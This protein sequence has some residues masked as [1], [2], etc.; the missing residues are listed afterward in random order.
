MNHVYLLDELLVTSRILAVL[1]RQTTELAFHLVAQLQRV[2]LAKEN[3]LL[4]LDVLHSVA[5]SRVLL[6]FDSA[7]GRRA[8]TKER[9][10]C[11]NVCQFID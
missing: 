6:P 8:L 2:W 4:R 7:I 10:N 3:D 9:K 5:Y 1:L 11:Y